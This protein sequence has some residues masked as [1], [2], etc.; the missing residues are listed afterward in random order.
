MLIKNL[1]KII[2]LTAILSTANAYAGNACE[3]FQIKLANGL[4][5][6]V[7]I[8]T[9]KIE[10]DKASFQ[11]QGISIIEKKSDA[12][13]TVT[14]ATEEPMHA[15]I[16]FHSLS[17]PNKSMEIKF[18]LTDKNLYCEHDQEEM[19]GSNVQLEKTRLPGQVS[20]TIK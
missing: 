20:Y 10:G 16:S 19:D 1:I 14:Q 7:A 8:T 9:L 11:P 5:D 13:F 6:K 2:G 4:E 18:T 15:T 17:I 3:G 12:V